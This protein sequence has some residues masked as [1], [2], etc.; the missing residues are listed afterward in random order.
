M[1]F[2]VACEHQKE[3]GPASGQG[4]KQKGERKIHLERHF[5]RIIPNTQEGYWASSRTIKKRGKNVNVRG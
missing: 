4:G 5:T 1:G 3:S 2:R